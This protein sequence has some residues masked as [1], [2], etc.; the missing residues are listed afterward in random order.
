[1]IDGRPEIAPASPRF[2]GQV[3]LFPAQTTLR[4]ITADKVRNKLVAPVHGDLDLPRLT[5]CSIQGR[6][7]DVDAVNPTLVGAVL[8]A[9][10]SDHE[11]RAMGARAEPER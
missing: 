3:D 5:R 1:M 8:P 9:H 2:E 10:P 6:H 11:A 7:A 4:T